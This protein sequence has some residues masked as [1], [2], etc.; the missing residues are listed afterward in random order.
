MWAGCATAQGDDAPWAVDGWTTSL[1]CH[2]AGGGWLGSAWPP[3]CPQPCCVPPP[4]LGP[5]LP[6]PFPA[7]EPCGQDPAPPGSGGRLAGW[8]QRDVKHP[9][10]GWRVL[11]GC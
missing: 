2:H 10:W 1:N 3:A 6:D 11:W 4:Q 7:Q 9:A 5:L 8:G